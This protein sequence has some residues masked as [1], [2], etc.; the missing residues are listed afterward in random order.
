MAAE[1]FPG[2]V[3]GTLFPEP[4]KTEADG[5]ERK[6]NELLRPHCVAPR[7]LKIYKSL[8]ACHCYM[9]TGISVQ[10]L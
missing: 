5:E 1:R 4:E 3:G 6:R 7:E 2:E 9:S 10:T 8:A